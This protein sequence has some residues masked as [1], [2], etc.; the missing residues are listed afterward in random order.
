ML[1]FV[2][3]AIFSDGQVLHQFKDDEQ[4]Q[5][6]LFRDVLTRQDDLITFNLT[7]AMSRK[8]YQV[9]LVHG[10]IHI[11]DPGF[12][13]QIEAEVAG[14]DKRKY[15][16]IYFR[17]CQT[18]IDLFSDGSSKA[19]LSDVLCYFLGFQYTENDRNSKRL[20]CIYTN[21]EVYLI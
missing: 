13:S 6:V 5:E 10:K 1:G 3:T 17:R 9:D 4:Q 7:N 12:V 11:F 14:T 21:D 16:L 15:R 19:S 18:K 2:W 8:T 20:L